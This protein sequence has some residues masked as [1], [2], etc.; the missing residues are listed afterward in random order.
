MSDPSSCRTRHPVTRLLACLLLCLGVGH[1]L[2]SPFVYRVSGRS[3]ACS[4]LPGDRVV[5]TH[6]PIHDLG[7]V[8]VFRHWNDPRELVIKRV[9]GVPGSEVSVEASLDPVPKT[10]GSFDSN[11]TIR[12]LGQVSSGEAFIA[13]P[14]EEAEF[15]RLAPQNTLHDALTVPPK[16]YFML[17]DNRPSSADSRHYGPIPDSMIIGEVVL[18][19]PSIRRLFEEPCAVRQRWLPRIPPPGSDLAAFAATGR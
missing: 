4:F 16:H 13:F 5:V 15:R 3:M 10:K 12:N 17:G 2:I 14:V 1:F 9:A 11:F 8:L 18:I 7:D 19:L 6:S